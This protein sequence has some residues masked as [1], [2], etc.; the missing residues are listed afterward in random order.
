MADR[1]AGRLRDHPA[2]G[3]RDLLRSGRSPDS[4][5][6]AAR[7]PSAT[8]PNAAWDVI[9]IHTPFR[10]HQIGVAL[11][12]RTGVPTVES[13]HTFFEEYAAHYLPWLPAAWLR[14]GGSPV[15]AAPLPRRRSP[16]RADATDG[17]CA[18]A[19]TGYDAVVG[20]PDRSPSS[21]EFRGGDGDRFRDRNMRSRA[22]HR[23]TW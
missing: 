22:R 11:A 19:D 2:A 15:L 14:L 1:G 21:T 4:E 8:W 9:H 23:P 10:A 12:R 18:R 20:D 17:R 16:D 3:A 7:P 13:Y 5:R 6:S